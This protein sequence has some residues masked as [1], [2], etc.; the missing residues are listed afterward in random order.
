MPEYSGSL[1]RVAVA[2]GLW[3]IPLLPLLAALLLGWPRARDDSAKNGRE[4]WLAAVAPAAALA[5][6]GYFTWVLS[7]RPDAERILVDHVW[8]FVRIGSLDAALSFSLDSLSAFAACG[9]AFVGAVV[10]VFAVTSNVSRFALAAMNLCVS[11][12][13][14]VVLAQNAVIL[15]LGSGLGGVSVWLLL[16]G[17]R[18]A[19]RG[20]VVVQS[21]LGDAVIVVATLLTFWVLGGTWTEAGEYVPEFRPRVAGVEIVTP[22]GHEPPKLDREAGH[23][24]MISPQAATAYI[25]GAAICEVDAAGRPG[26]LGPEANPCK[27]VARS[28][29]VRI[30]IGP[31]RHDLR[32]VTS[33]GNDAT[34]AERTPVV[35]GQ[36]T[37]MAPVASTFGFREVHNQLLI[38]DVSGA[39]VLRVALL[40]KTLWGINVVALICGLLVVAGLVKSS[41]V[42]FSGW[43]GRL[44]DTPSYAV[45]LVVTLGSAVGAFITVR[46]GFLFDLAPTASG[47]LALVGAMACLLTAAAGVFRADYRTALACF[48]ASQ[49]G[50]VLVGAGVGAFA[51]AAYQ[52]VAQAVGVAAILLSIDAVGRASSREGA[53]LDEL[54]GSGAE[55]PSLAKLVFV[56]AAGVTAAPIPGLLGLWARDG[57]TATAFAIDRIGFVPGWMVWGFLGLG[58]FLGSFLVWRVYYVIFASAPAAKKPTKKKKRKA[59]PLD[60]RLLWVLRVLAVVLV[61]GG[62]VGVQGRY[63]GSSHPALIDTWLASAFAGAGAPPS[64]LSSGVMLG[65]LFGQFSL[66]LAGW[67]AARSRY[68]RERSKSWRSDEER[69][70]Q[71]QRYSLELGVYGAPAGLASGVG[72]LAQVV[73]RIDRS[74]LGRRFDDS[75]IEPPGQASIGSDEPAHEDSAESSSGK[76]ESD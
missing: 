7:A 44:K 6:L 73:A 20:D 31:S 53:D 48:G 1:Q 46:W 68:G 55:H 35:A 51:G 14:V 38:R 76:E 22:E 42:P 21:F 37:E 13:L 60:Q 70:G 2:E 32:V 26:G 41:L 27:K 23:V 4:R 63:W 39:R 69:Y 74:L 65:Q 64:L 57:V 34:V 25:G 24:T 28:P 61:V 11:A 16:R 33:R 36:E 3:L 67:A 49:L 47:A 50:V 56:V 8:T 30:P 19:K 9:A 45:A 18:D 58:G 71:V 40:N 52:L 10:A 15:T 59:R 17:E 66:S 62:I 54:A 12:F 72:T 43:L 75:R 29:F 5:L